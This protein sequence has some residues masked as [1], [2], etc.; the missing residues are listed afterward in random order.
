ML[1]QRDRNS[2]VRYARSVAAAC[3]IALGGL[4]SACAANLGSQSNAT[5]GDQAAES[6]PAAGEAQGF[7]NAPPARGRV[8]IAMILPLA[9]VTQAS[10]VGQSMKQAGELAL[11]ERDNPAI[12]L[13]VKDD[14]GTEEGAKAAA[15]AA[16]QEGAEIIVGPLFARAVKGA[17]DVGRS[18]QPNVPLLAFSNDRQVAGNGVYLMSFLP[19]PE[20]DRVIEFAARAGKRRY[21]AL[22]PDTA[23]GHLVEA[24]FRA[25]VR[26]HGGTIVALERYPIESNAMLEPAQRVLEIA[27]Q[28]GQPDAASDGAL[29]GA[30]DAIFLPG[31]ADVL[32]KIGPLVTYA[33]IDTERVQ[34]IG[35]GAWDFPNIGRDKVF[36]GGWYASPDPRGWRA[37]SERFAR[38][39][40]QAPP[41]MATFAYDAVSIAIEL[42]AYPP[43][44]RYTQ[45]NLTRPA[46]FA[47]IEGAVRLELDGTARRDLAVLEVQRFGATVVD[48]ASGAGPARLPIETGS[49]P[50]PAA[51]PRPVAG[52]AFDAGG[53]SAP[54]W[55][56]PA[57][58]GY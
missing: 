39:Y 32:P 58:S 16:I 25:A 28:A 6:V 57:Q 34:L 27:K 11:F 23:Y 31:G 56:A 53:P 49:T 1:R 3:V 7:A 8:K 13:I 33:G 35:T 26:R 47:G 42:S 4:L 21:V 40:G 55:T 18:V 46:G 15:T 48:P 22:I 29:E 20:V 12:E 24:A 38:T 51:D 44:A 43:G 5:L 54:P 50:A 41:R 30:I 2:N 36:V 45:A 52:G 37:F 9:G 17:A 10:L 14:G 19:E